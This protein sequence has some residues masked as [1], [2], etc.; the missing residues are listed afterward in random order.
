MAD[1][2]VTTDALANG[3]FT[4]TLMGVWLSDLIGFCFF[5]GPSIAWHKT[6]DGG[7]TWTALPERLQTL[8]VGT[9]IAHWAGWYDGWTRQTTNNKFYY[10]WIERVDGSTTGTLFFGRFDVTTEDAQEVAAT[11][12]NIAT[13]P[14]ITTGDECCTISVAID[15]SLMVTA[16]WGDSNFQSW[17]SDTGHIWT[18]A[19]EWDGIPVFH[20]RQYLTPGDA[21]PGSF[22]LIEF[23]FQSS[24]VFGLYNPAAGGWQQFGALDQNITPTDGNLLVPDNGAISY[25]HSD[26]H[27]LFVSF[28]ESRANATNTL[29]F[30]DLVVGVAISDVFTNVSGNFQSP[31]IMVDHLT[32]D[33]IVFYVEFISGQTALWRR[34]S[35]DGGATWGAAV[36]VNTTNRMYEM[37]G[38]PQ[39]NV[40]GLGRVQPYYNNTLAN[41]LD[42]IYTNNGTSLFCPTLVV[43]PEIQVLFKSK[44]IDCGGTIGLGEFIVDDVVNAQLVIR[45]EG[46][47]SLVLGTLVD[48]NDIS[49]LAGDDPSG[50][51]ILLGGQTTVS[52]VLDTSTDGAKAGFITIPSNDADEASCTIN[53]TATVNAAPIPTAPTCPRYRC[54]SPG[55]GMM[56]RDQLGFVNQP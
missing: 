25:R 34:I 30:Y 13:L 56:H 29:R 47:A 17:V 26:Q 21:G 28:I 33:I 27:G 51:T 24:Y 31:G 23:I 14:N 46:D 41:P 9:Y 37:I 40:T 42:T 12:R 7:L 32:G 38:V 39:C 16:F 20:A 4:R 54:R 44:L 53:F 5:Y 43:G 1:D 3:W 18:E 10:C 22:Y 48:G 36:Q 55:P 19:G 52:V 8:F 35:T 2:V 15:G 50:E 45:N 6:T 49:I 11:K